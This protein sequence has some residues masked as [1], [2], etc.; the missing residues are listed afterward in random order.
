MLMGL[1]FN[2]NT[3]ITMCKYDYKK[4]MCKCLTIEILEGGL[5][6]INSKKVN[7]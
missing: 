5:N 4:C 1:V 7:A 6:Y 2:D 3:S